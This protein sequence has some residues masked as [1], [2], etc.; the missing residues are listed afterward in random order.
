MHPSKKLFWVVAAAAVAV[1]AFMAFGQ[2]GNPATVF[3]QSASSEGEET[4]TTED[5]TPSSLPEETTT[6]LEPGTVGSI[7]YVDPGTGDILRT[8][9][10][11]EVPP[12]ATIVDP[13]PQPPQVN[14]P[15]QG[16]EGEPE[17]EPEPEPTT[18]TTQAP[19]P[20]PTTIPT[21]AHRV[22]VLVEGDVLTR[23]Q[24]NLIC[25]NGDQW[26]WSA[27]GGQVLDTQTWHRPQEQFDCF[28]EY[29]PQGGHIDFV[30][31]DI[32]QVTVSL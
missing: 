29:W 32:E 8:D 22:Q 23:T 21:Y 24:V 2:V 10:P 28:V 16:G 9:D 17:G 6:T 27:S 7:V 12:G 5:T 25:E 14:E 20:P 15:P 4:T 31:D 11:S 13:G 26:S 18:T 1:L 19:P 30:S 3:V